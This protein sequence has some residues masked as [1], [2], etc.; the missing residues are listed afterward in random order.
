MLTLIMIMSKVD[1]SFHNHWITNSKH[2]SNPLQLLKLKTFP[3]FC[4]FY[5]G[6]RLLILDLSISTDFRHLIGQNQVK[7]QNGPIRLVRSD[8][9]Q[10]GRLYDLEPR[11]DNTLPKCLCF[12]QA[13]ASLW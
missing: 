12:I 6:P 2:P 13:G 9:V 7:Q 8:F 10:E 3:S 5:Q 1:V 11:A 4:L